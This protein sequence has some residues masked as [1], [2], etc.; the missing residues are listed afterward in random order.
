[1][2][3]KLIPVLAAAGAVVVASLVVPATAQAHNSPGHGSTH[4]SGHSTPTYV[5]P[6][7]EWGTCSNATLNAVGAQCGFVTVPLN[8]DKPKGT[9]IK[10]A[11][12]RVQHNPDVTSQGPILI[13]PGGPGGSGLIY[14]AIG[15]LW[16]PQDVSES[17]DWIGFDPRGVGSSVPS[18]SCIS[19]FDGYNRPAYVPD[20]QKLFN[21]WT[22]LSKKYARACL[23]NGGADLLN[24][25]TTI[26]AAKD[27][28]SIRIALNAPQINYYGFSYGT[29]LGQVYNNLFPG[30]M[31]RVIYDG[32]VDPTRVWYSSNLDQNIAFEKTIKVYFTWVA[33]NDSIYHLGTTE[34]AV[35][36]KYYKELD[37]LKKSPAGGIIGPD[38]FTDVLLSAGYYV[39]GWDDIGHAFADLV[40]DGDYSGVQ[41]LF[42]GPDFDD[43]GH[44][45]Y[46]AVICT[47]AQWPKNFA[48]VTND[49]WRTNA[50]APFETWGNAW[51]NGPCNYWP[52][53]AQGKP[54]NIKGGNTSALLINET[55]DAATPYSGALEVRKRYPDSVLIEGV[56]GTTH[57]GSMSGVSCTDD[58]IIEY[59]RTGKLP[60]RTG[61]NH[62]DVQC[63]PVPAP[64]ATS[65]DAAAA[66]A[67]SSSAATTARA[68]IREG[69]VKAGLP[70]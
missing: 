29:Y 15:Q 46:L 69:L 3:T 44:A 45:I 57:A 62:S 53:K 39:Y 32:V 30:K 38:E 1:M 52:A 7:V 61:G 50:K 19:D 67:A 66:T 10:L 28:D 14:A 33:E 36:K 68:M 42:G 12:S 55:L 11:V 24:N 58:K 59:L 13:N 70:G 41:S 23:Q 40:N 6:P 43:N 65:T 51:F 56:G 54:L 63:P 16:F 8:Y 48:K 9:K 64:A 25:L 21:T 60:K 5:P 22:S 2:R 18:L 17:Y 37:K 27:M 47:D 35:E 4:G 49:N 34:K 31:R 20:T 26:D